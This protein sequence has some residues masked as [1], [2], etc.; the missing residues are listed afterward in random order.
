[1]QNKLINL[2]VR[3]LV[4]TLGLGFIALGIALSI[5]S[6]L[7]IAPVSC[8]TVLAE[9]WKNSITI[10]NITLP[11]TVGVYTVIM[12]LT[13]I[14]IQII[15]LRRNFKISSL[16]QLPAAFALGILTDL[17]I[18]SCTWIVAETYSMKIILCFLSILITALGISL[19]VIA[20][21]WMLAGEETVAAISKVSHIKFEDIKVI[22]DV[23]MVVLTI[24]FSLILFNSWI[25]DG[26]TVIVREGTVIVAIFTGLFMKFT[27][28]FATKI[29][30]KVLKVGE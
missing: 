11:L 4:A 1:M 5:K 29:F 7:G 14:A 2:T 12:H 3:Y 27:T 30:G 19:E 21:A 8:P 16:M 13:F 18:W 15:L 26:V 6:D 24:V 28:P 22:F 10:G 9:L 20:N 25:G 17:S 23:A